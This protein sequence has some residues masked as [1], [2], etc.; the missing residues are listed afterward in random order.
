MSADDIAAW[1]TAIWDEDAVEAE[2]DKY[3]DD[4]WWMNGPFEA[5]FVKARIAAD[6][7][8][9]GRYVE[10]VE[11]R[12]GLAPDA[13]GGANIAVEHLGFAVATLASAHA[14]RPGYDEQW[15]P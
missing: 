6:R 2:S 7:Q 12:D 3:V 10:L 14:D 13:R 9:L 5:D 15:R 4:C 11:W 1:L 8:I